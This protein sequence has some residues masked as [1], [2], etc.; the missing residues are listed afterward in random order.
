VKSIYLDFFPFTVKVA[1]GGLKAVLY[2]FLSWITAVASGLWPLGMTVWGAV[3]IC[4]DSARSKLIVKSRVK[5]DGMD[6]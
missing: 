4:P 5:E 3:S 6:G 1:G 2:F